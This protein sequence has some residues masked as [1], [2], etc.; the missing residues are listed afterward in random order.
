MNHLRHTRVLMVCSVF[1]LNSLCPALAAEDPEARQ[2]ELDAAC[3]AAR[4]EKL[5]P[6]R[7]KYTE[8]CITEQGNDPDYCK[9]FYSD[10]GNAMKNRQPMFLDLPE[11]IEAFE[12]S[13]SRQQVEG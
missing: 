2:K 9:R 3:E 11:C 1:L 5:I 8:E 13:N 6:L 4:L 7:K 10:Y 12:Y